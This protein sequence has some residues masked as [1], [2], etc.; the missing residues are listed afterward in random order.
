MPYLLRAFQLC[1]I[2]FLYVARCRW[3]KAIQ[4]SF[5]LYPPDSAILRLLIVRLVAR[6]AFAKVEVALRILGGTK[7]PGHNG[8]G[9]SI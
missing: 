7:G 6:V 3:S 5:G 9:P 8:A 4:S 2:T 1:S